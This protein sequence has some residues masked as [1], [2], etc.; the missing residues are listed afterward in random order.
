V[1]GGR[2]WIAVALVIFAGYRPINAVAGALLFGTTTALGFLGQA[3]NWPVAA[4]VLSMLPYLATLLLLIVPV[5]ASPAMRR[6]MAAPAAL[7]LAYFRD[8]R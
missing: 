4:P 5:A 8:E 2:G 6:R 1:V 3:R 7:G